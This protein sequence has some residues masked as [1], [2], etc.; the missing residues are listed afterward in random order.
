MTL[1]VPGAV[2]VLAAFPTLAEA[3]GPLA[4]VA[5]SYL[6]KVGREPAGLD[7]KVIDGDLRIWLRVPREMTVDVLDYRG[8]PY[9]RF[10]RAGVEV[11]RNSSMYYL[12]QTPVPETPPTSLRAS[13]PP[14]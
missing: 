7:A 12:N 2:L 6:A 14:S 8:A 3:H 5:S 10:M 13:T 4:P 1:A 11:N 9:L